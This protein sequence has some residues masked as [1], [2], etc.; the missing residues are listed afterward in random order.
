MANQSPPES[1]HALDIKALQASNVSFFTARTT[2]V[3]GDAELLGCAALKTLGRGAGELK[4]MRTARPHLRKGIAARLLQHVI[5]EARSRGMHTISLETGTPD[6]FIPARKL[7][8]RF[9]FEV[10][11]PFGD[12]VE[13]P[14]SVCMRYSIKHP[15]GS[16]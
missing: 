11:P 10:C 12:Y 16:N 8:L 14:F 5:N 1:V 6:S 2:N 4:S 15:A 9:G 7:Y 3:S 13:D